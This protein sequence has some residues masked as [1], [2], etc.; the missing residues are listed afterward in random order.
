MQTDLQSRV[1][2]LLDPLLPAASKP[3]KPLIKAWVLRQSDQELLT[4]MS[5]LQTALDL[6]AG[7]GGIARDTAKRARR[8]QA[9]DVTHPLRIVHGGINKAP[10]GAG[11]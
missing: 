9:T 3:F 10:P 6:A 1:L 8:S 2:T 11:L 4:M 7:E 5:R